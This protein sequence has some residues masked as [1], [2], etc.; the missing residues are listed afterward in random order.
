MTP[1]GKKVYFTST[2]DLTADNSDTDTSADLY[3]WSEASPRR[4]T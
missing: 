4:I 2:E 3:M 1:D